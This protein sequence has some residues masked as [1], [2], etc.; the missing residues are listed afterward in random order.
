VKYFVPPIS[1]E[2]IKKQFREL[3]KKLHPDK[4]GDQDKFREMNEERDRLL[5]LL[6]ELPSLK[7]ILQKAKVRKRGN[8]PRR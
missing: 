5:S 2:S 6:P 3:S 8:R 4:G 7:S 1:E